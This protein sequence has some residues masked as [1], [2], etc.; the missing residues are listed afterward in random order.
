MAKIAGSLTSSFLMV[1]SI[2]FQ[3]GTWSKQSVSMYY[4]HVLCAKFL[5]PSF[6]NVHLNKSSLWRKVRIIEKSE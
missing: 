6:E 4:L 3:W 1:F 5:E 2:S